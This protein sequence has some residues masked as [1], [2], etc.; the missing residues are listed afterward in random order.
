MRLAD[1][2]KTLG[3][4]PLIRALRQRRGL[5]QATVGIHLQI[6]R[7]TITM[8]EN[9]TDKLGEGRARKFA[10][11]FDVPLK[12]FWTSPYAKRSQP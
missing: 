11:Y 9:G 1:H 2:E 12:R 6:V 3:P 10:E 7:P 5:T 4:G 8:I